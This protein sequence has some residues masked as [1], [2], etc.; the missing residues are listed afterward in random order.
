MYS[1][2]YRQASS[3]SRIRQPIRDAR[4]IQFQWWQELP[5]PIRALVVAPIS[6]DLMQEYEIQADRTKGYDDDHKPCYCAFR[7]VLTQ[8]RSDDDEVF[9]EAPV[10]A[11]TLTS[12][13]LLDARWLICRTTV[14]NFDH[15]RR[16]T[17]FSLSDTM[18]R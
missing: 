12:W 18:P 10:Y 16:Q 11:E 2:L 17:S 8:L 14:D 1:A 5:S 7:Y 9:Y 3:A 6:F 15:G 4:G 13:R